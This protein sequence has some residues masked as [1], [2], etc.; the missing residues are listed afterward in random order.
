MAYREK[1]F[2]IISQK[3]IFENLDLVISYD[4]TNPN[5]LVFCLW[6]NYRWDFFGQYILFLDRKPYYR[7]NV[8]RTS[9]AKLEENGKTMVAG[10]CH[11][12]F[13]S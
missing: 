13:S 4:M 5:V 3:T 6:E 8:Q 2:F 1:L 10:L 11:F 9:A 7:P 12:V